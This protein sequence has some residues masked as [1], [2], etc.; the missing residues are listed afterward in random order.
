MKQVMMIIPINADENKTEHV[1]EKGGNFWLEVGHAGSVR[2]LQFQHH[3]RDDHCDHTVAKCLEAP[4]AHFPVS[5][6]RTHGSRRASCAQAFAKSGCAAP[7][8]CNVIIT[9]D[10]RASSKLA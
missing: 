8:G 3:D 4:L 7:L 6:V 10:V 9:G 2:G 5:R 1:A